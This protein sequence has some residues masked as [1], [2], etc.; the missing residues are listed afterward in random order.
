[1]VKLTKEGLQ[2]L[3]DGT[4]GAPQHILG[5][6][7]LEGGGL[8]VRTIQPHADRVDVVDAGTGAALPM[9]K[10]HAAGVYEWRDPSRSTLRYRL[11]VTEKDEVREIEDPYRFPPQIS[12]FDLHLHGEGQNY[13]A[14]LTMGAHPAVVD[15]VAGVRFGVWA[16]NALRVSVIGDFNRWD[17]RGHPMV[18]RNDGGIWELFVPGLAAGALYKFEV[19]GRH[20][21]LQA[22]SDPFGFAAEVRPQTASRVADPMSYAWRDADWMRRRRETDWG[23]RPISVYEVHAGSWRRRAKEGDRFLT[24]REMADEL[25]PYVKELGYTHIEFLP[26]SEHPFDGS[27]GYQT[28]GYFAATSRFGEPADFQYFV[29]QAHQAGLGVILDWVPAHFPRDAHGLAYFDGTNLYEHADPRQGEH[30]DWGTLIFNYGRN[31]VRAFLLSNA[32]FWADV[33]HI[34]GLRVDAVA[35]MLYLDYSR[36]AGEWIPNKHGGRENLEA[37]EFLRKFGEVIHAEF[38][39][40]LTF[41]EESTAWPSVSRPVYLGGLGFGL[42]WNM[43]WMHDTLEYFSK[44]PVHRKYHHNNLTFSMI[45]AFTENFILPFSHDEVVHGKRSMLD[46][47]PGDLWQKFANLRLLYAYFYAHPGKK[48]LFM[49]G[50]F[51]QW[52]EWNSSAALDWSLLDYDLHR[53][54]RELVRD[55]NRLYAGLPPLHEVDFSWEGFEWIDY[56]DSEQ[57]ALSFLRRGKKADDI[58]VAVFN[59]TPVP[60]RDYRL[61][62]PLPGDYLEILNTDSALYG[63]GNIG[64]AGRVRAEDKPWDGK[65]HSLVLTLP[66]LGALYLRPAPPA[67]AEEEAPAAESAAVVPP[68]PAAGTDE[69]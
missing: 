9:E 50:E 35:S 3:A 16:P 22:K 66:P 8:V 43:G 49:G 67:P 24:Y 25:I 53:Q 20:G 68:A 19:R 48:L 63:G 17:G 61:G 62:V 30:K 6:H 38:P 52:S 54:L 39:G 34:D 12:D 37:V 46:K 69:G 60:R 65:P 41:A 31:E 18:K 36:K 42:K 44:D 51:G 29:D 13:R 56:H 33:Y 1:M 27:W 28:V 10:I 23:T 5:R 21:F 45:Y 32:V 14:Y 7:T 55:L 47:M 40:I 11:R 59:A 58:V 4:H 2:S 15:G 57:S 26:L 64:N